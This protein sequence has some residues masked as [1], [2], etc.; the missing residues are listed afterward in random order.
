MAGAL[1]QTH[2][3]TVYMDRVRDFLKRAQ[4]DGAVD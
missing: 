1:V 2:D 3:R 4:T